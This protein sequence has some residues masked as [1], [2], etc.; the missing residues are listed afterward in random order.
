MGIAGLLPFLAPVTRPV[1]L[2]D[3]RGRRVAVDAYVW[4][5]R[6]AAACPAD[7]LLLP[8][9]PLPASTTSASGPGAADR[10]TRG[11]FGSG[12]SR[13]YDDDGDDG[14][15]DETLNADSQPLGQLPQPPDLKKP[16]GLVSSTPNLTST[17]L[18]RLLT[19]S[20]AP[21]GWT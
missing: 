17:T 6:G 12:H 2:Q 9:Q 14:D 10:H 16:P 3:L 15:D 21:S 20:T 18:Q 7:L 4:L 19:N 13:S 11:A 1:H 8:S 5:H